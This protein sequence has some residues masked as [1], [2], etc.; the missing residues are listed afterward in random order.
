MVPQP[1]AL[2][3]SADDSLSHAGMHETQHGRHAMYWA[4]TVSTLSTTG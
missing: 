3:P 2:E 1:G 4:H